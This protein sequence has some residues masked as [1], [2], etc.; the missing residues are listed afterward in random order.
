VLK[1]KNQ[2]LGLVH[3]L[4]AYVIGLGFALATLGTSPCAFALAST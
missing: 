2:V 4:G 1:H 3:G